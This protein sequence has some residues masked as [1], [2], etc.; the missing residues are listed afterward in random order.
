MT[1]TKAIVDS[2]HIGKPPMSPAAPAGVPN[3]INI[4]LAATAQAAENAQAME[5]Q[6]KA[7]VLLNSPSGAA[8]IKANGVATAKT[9]AAMKAGTYIASVS[10]KPMPQ[11]PTITASTTG[12]ACRP[13]FCDL[14]TQSNSIRTPKYRRKPR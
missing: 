7:R 3:D 12:I 11:N 10:G 13:D 5:S 4:P 9:I 2:N 1:V 6:R 14:S 8:T